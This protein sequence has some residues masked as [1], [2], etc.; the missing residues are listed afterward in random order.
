MAN[1]LVVRKTDRTIHVVPVEQEAFYKSM[2]NRLK[3]NDRMVLEVMSEEEAKKL[4]FYD[5]NFKGAGAANAEIRE[6]DERI[7]EL[8]QRLAALQGGGKSEETAQEKIARIN[9][10]TSLEDVIL[11]TGDDERKTVKDAAE[12]KAASFQ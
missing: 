4:P 9:A 10:A 1:V 8:E 3:A 12:K 7:A 5:K 2:N 11:I 6:K